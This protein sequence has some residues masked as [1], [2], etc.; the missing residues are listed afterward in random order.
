MTIEEFDNLKPGV[1]VIIIGPSNGSPKWQQF[2]GKTVK[3]SGSFVPGQPGVM[4]YWPADVELDGKA[5]R[6]CIGWPD[7]IDFPA[8]QPV[9]TN[10]CECGAYAVGIK[11]W[12]IGHSSWC[13]VRKI[14]V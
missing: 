2:I 14:D 10:P 6:L 11:P 4:S 12:E 3:I 5:Y 7:D 8:T 1:E 9:R 13:P